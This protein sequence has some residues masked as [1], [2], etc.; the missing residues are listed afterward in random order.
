MIRRP[1][2]STLFPYTTL[3]RSMAVWLGGLV[4]LGVFLLRRAHPR[5]LGVVLPAWSRWATMA[6]VW[7][8]GG[9]AGPAGVQGGASGAAG[10]GGRESPRL[11]STDA[12]L[13]Y[14]AF[15][16]ENNGGSPVPHHG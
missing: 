14:G 13:L 3:F 11:H 8:G 2:R 1:P 10:Q 5:V 12:E 4:T 7:L 16:F 15:C 9:G 6:V